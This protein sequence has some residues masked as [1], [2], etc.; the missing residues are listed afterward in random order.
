MGRTLTRAGSLWVTRLLLSLAL[1]GLAGLDVGH[2]LLGERSAA[3]ETPSQTPRQSPGSAPAPWPARPAEPC[4]GEFHTE[5]GSD[6]H[7]RDLPSSRRVNDSS[8]S[9]RLDGWAGRAISPA[10]SRKARPPLA[11]DASAASIF[12]HI[13][14]P[15]ERQT[16]LLRRPGGKP[17]RASW[18][19]KIARSSAPHDAAR[20]SGG[21]CHERS[22]QQGTGPDAPAGIRG[23]EQDLQGT[24]LSTPG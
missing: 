18:Q 12:A 2:D 23:R 22:G 11:T 10:M 6:D 5:H 7:R 8:L 15:R 9:L 20:R 14:L 19:P 3:R 13:T 16:A 17:R 24:W 1:L 4:R 21:N